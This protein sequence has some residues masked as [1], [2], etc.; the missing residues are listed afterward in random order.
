MLHLLDK[1]YSKNCNI[2]KYYYN[3]KQ[4]FSIWIYFKM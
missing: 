1:K 4:L 2:M 3:L